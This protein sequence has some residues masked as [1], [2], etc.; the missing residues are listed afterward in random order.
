MHHRSSH[1]STQ[2]RHSIIFDDSVNGPWSIHTHK[3][4]VTRSNISYKSGSNWCARSLQVL[5]H[6]PRAHVRIRSAV[7]LRENTRLMALQLWARGVAEGCAGATD[8]RRSKTT[9]WEC[10]GAS[11]CLSIRRSTSPA[12][13]AIFVPLC[14][15]G[16]TV[17]RSGWRR[18]TAPATHFAASFGVAFDEVVL[19]RGTG[20]RHAG[21]SVGGPARTVELLLDDVVLMSAARP[22]PVPRYPTPLPEKH[23]EGSSSSASHPTAGDAA[24]GALRAQRTGWCHYLSSAAWDL[25]TGTAASAAHRPADTSQ[26]PSCRLVDGD[27]LVGRWAQNC[28]PTSTAIRRPDVLSSPIHPGARTWT[29]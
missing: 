13:T 7:P 14:A 4:T 22:P 19:L 26:L 15:L 29:C 23:S 27:H 17:G 11:A 9:G 12:T 25:A 24:G 6:G 28:A 2:H 1:G 10:V 16:Q 20:G 5:M 8:R 18:L 21:N 3:A